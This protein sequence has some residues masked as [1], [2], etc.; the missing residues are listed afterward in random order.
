MGVVA[1]VFTSL[2]FVVGHDA[3][4][5][6]L[7]PHRRLN[8]IL[9]TLAFLP[10]LHPFGLWDLGHNRIHHRHTNR[11]GKD[12]VGQL[13]PAE[14]SQLPFL[15]Q[16]RY[17]FFRTAA[18]HYWYY[19]YEIWWK[20]MFLPCASDIGGYR[21]RYWVHLS[22]VTGWMVIWSATI[23]GVTYE[24]SGRNVQHC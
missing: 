23:A 12:Y 6:S 19:L 8:R 15:Q 16:L 17:R 7:T 9:G 14:F 21:T 5:H 2:L 13:T 22:I 4:H 10:C 20:K 11:R 18:G 3:C 1:G 24:L